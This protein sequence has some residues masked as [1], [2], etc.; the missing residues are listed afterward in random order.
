MSSFQ[1]CVMWVSIAAYRERLFT[2]YY[3]KFPIILT[4]SSHVSSIDRFNY[5]GSA[6]TAN[7]SKIS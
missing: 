3:T 7:D 2:K 6:Y 1:V 5:V 4:T